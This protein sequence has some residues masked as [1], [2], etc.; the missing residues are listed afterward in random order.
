MLGHARQNRERYEVGSPEA[1]AALKKLMRTQGSML[2]CN[3]GGWRY[4][5]GR[6]LVCDSVRSGFGKLPRV[7]EAPPG[8][9]PRVA[10]QRRTSSVHT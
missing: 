4:C 2:G 6:L 5:A 10:G 1:L 7:V 9:N 8:E 3:L